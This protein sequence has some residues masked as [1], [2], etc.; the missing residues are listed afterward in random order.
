MAFSDL[1]R[2]LCVAMYEATVPHV[3]ELTP[4]A[5]DVL[6]T[7][8][9]GTTAPT[10]WASDGWE[11]TEA[12]MRASRDL[13]ETQSWVSKLPDAV[14]RIAGVL[15]VC[16]AGWEDRAPVIP[17]E[18]MA[19]ACE[20]GAYLIPHATAAIGAVHEDPTTRLVRR[21]VAW[22]RDHNWPAT[23]N[24]REVRRS[25]NAS[26]IDA[27]KAAALLAGR[28]WIRP[29]GTT[30]PAGGRPSSDYATHPNIAAVETP[31]W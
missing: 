21:I 7:F 5:R 11:G 28:G 3:V 8:V 4:D 23:F 29:V 17:A 22:L 18:T 25:L 2:D 15:H 26:S 6:R 19:A 31:T 20:I 10:P 27:G 14:A 30:G 1:V 12:R 16:E 9:E 13:H 24:L